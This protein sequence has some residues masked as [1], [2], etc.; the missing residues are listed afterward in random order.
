VRTIRNVPVVRH[1]RG[2]LRPTPP[3]SDTTPRPAQPTRPSSREG[4]RHDSCVVAMAAS[5]GGPPALAT[6]LAGLRNVTGP[7][8]IVQHI[9][10]DFVGG[11]ISWMARI[12]PL[13]VVLARHGSP[14]L[15]GH[16]YI[17]PGDSHLRLGPGRT[18]HLTQTPVTVHRPSAD[19]LFESVARHAGANSVGVLLTGMG[20]DGAAG[21]Q[22]MHAEGAHTI[23][24]DKDT[25]AVYGMPRAAK[26]LGA[27]T[28]ELPLGSIAEA[29]VR[30]GST[31]RSTS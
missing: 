27:A 22:M 18:V 20:D 10:P 24:Q 28:Q 3:A 29:I 12:S 23:V 19:Q 11:L 16:V 9:H 2:R 26:L 31:R 17:G 25:S 15:D 21:L 13:P 30:A 6:V 4:S 5:T 1:L 7:V 14:M 8:L